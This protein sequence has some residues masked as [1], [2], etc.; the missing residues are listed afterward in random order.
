MPPSCQSWGSSAPCPCSIMWQTPD[1]LSR[2]WFISPNIACGARIYSVAEPYIAC[3]AAWRWGWVEGGGGSQGSLPNI[4]PPI[5]LLIADNLR[6]VI[7]LD[8]AS[9]DCL[10][11][12]I[13]NNSK[14]NVLVEDSFREL[15]ISLG[16][17]IPIS[18]MYLHMPDTCFRRPVTSVHGFW[19][20]FTSL[21]QCHSYKKSVGLLWSSLAVCGKGSHRI[22]MV[23]FG[24]L[25]TWFLFPGH[26]LGSKIWTAG[27]STIIRTL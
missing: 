8:R 1:T 15:S 18:D 26:S 27:S 5:W 21:L 24:K 6:D 25:N 2:S 7:I 12:S 20:S 16:G 17:I 13:P 9:M 10:L 4:R 23:E 14:L 11:Y 19:C 3:G 22:W